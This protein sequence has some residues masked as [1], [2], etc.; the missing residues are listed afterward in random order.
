[1]GEIMSNHEEQKYHSSF[2]TMILEMLLENGHLTDE[3]ILHLIIENNSADYVMLF[4]YENNYTQLLPAQL[5]RGESVPSGIIDINASNSVP[6][7][8][9]VNDSHFDSYKKGAICTTYNR[10]AYKS[11]PLYKTLNCFNVDYKSAVS[12]PLMLAGKL[13]EQLVIIRIHDDS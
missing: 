7:N 3:N 13:Y 10:E 8:I 6:I 5:V 2:Y 12:V 4:K 11:D 1:M 9:N